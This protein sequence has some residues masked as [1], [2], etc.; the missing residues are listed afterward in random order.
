MVKDAIK[1][2]FELGELNTGSFDTGYGVKEF[3]MITEPQLYLVLMRSG[4]SKGC[5]PNSEKA[6]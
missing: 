4:K 5:S 6:I 2:E 3:T 1:S